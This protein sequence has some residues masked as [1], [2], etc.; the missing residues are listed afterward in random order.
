METTTTYNNYTEE[1]VANVKMSTEGAIS[2]KALFTFLT[3][4][5]IVFTTAV[6]YCMSTNHVVEGGILIGAFA[7][8]CIYAASVAKSFK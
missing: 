7:M 4:A 3:G 5:A 6:Y 8:V 1:S 2:K